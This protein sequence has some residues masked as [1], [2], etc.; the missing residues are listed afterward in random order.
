MDMDTPIDT[1]M[2]ISHGPEL[3]YLSGLFRHV[4]PVSAVIPLLLFLAILSSLSNPC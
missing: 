4:F 3:A 2:D 1:D